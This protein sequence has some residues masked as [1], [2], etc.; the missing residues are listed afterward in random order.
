ME[1]ID[2][3]AESLAPGPKPKLLSR[4]LRLR[5]RLISFSRVSSSIRAIFASLIFSRGVRYDGEPIEGWRSVIAILD[6]RGAL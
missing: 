1:A 2:D 3:E 6:E 4:L 5:S